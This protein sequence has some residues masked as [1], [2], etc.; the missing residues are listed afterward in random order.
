LMKDADLMIGCPDA[1]ATVD[2][3]ATP[4]VVFCRSPQNV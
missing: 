3:A 2:A 4:A 1:A